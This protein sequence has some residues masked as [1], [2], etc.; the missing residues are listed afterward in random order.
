M[1]APKMIEQQ[2]GD[3]HDALRFGLDTKRGDIVERNQE[4]RKR[5]TLAER[6]YG[7]AFPFQLGIERQ[8][9]SGFPE[10]TR[11]NSILNA[12]TRGF[13]RKI[14][15]SLENFPSSGHAQWDGSSSWIV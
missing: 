10:A 8:M 14:L 7:A 1:E 12:R 6:V 3:S 15:V 5:I 4:H 11:T 2:I 13:D 9:L